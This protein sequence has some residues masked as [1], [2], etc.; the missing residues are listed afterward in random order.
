[1]TRILEKPLTKQAVIVAD[2]VVDEKNMSGVEPIAWYQ[3]GKD[4][5][6]YAV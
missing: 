6:I 5:A 1:M 3:E 4:A 2:L